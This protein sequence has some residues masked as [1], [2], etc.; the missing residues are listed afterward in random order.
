[1]RAQEWACIWA[2]G[3]ACVRVPGRLCVKALGRAC[4]QA[5]RWVDQTLRKE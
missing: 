3:L 2:P 1:M 5:L 4:V